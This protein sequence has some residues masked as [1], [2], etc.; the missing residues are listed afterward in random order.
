MV[1]I[2]SNKSANTKRLYEISKSLNERT[3]WVN[4]KGELKPKYFKGLN[5]VGVT[6]GASTPKESIQEI[7][8][9]LS[10]I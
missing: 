4:S 10:T 3:F 1:I 6:A 2:G 7:M 9:Y 5:S 8:E